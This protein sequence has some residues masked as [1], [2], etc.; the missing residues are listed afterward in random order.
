MA[1]S[2]SN[3][4]QKADVQSEY[5]PSIAPAQSEYAL[6][7]CGSLPPL[8]PLPQSQQSQQP[9]QPSGSTKRAAPKF[10]P[11]LPPIPSDQA[12]KSQSAK[13]QMGPD[14]SVAAPYYQQP[15][16][17]NR[18]PE[19][20][21]NKECGATY[22]A[23]GS[24][25]RVYVKFFRD[26]IGSVLWEVFTVLCIIYTSRH[27]TIP[28]PNQLSRAAIRGIFSCD[29][30][31]YRFP[32][33]EVYKRLAMRLGCLGIHNK[34]VNFL[35]FWRLTYGEIMRINNHLRN[36]SSFQDIELFTFGQDDDG[37]YFMQIKAND[38]TL[39]LVQMINALHDSMKAWEN[40]T[41]VAGIKLDD[42][43]DFTVRASP[44]Y[45]S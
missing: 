26:L 17:G 18:E 37:K 38:F 5:S 41:K 9:Q 19:I 21:Y 3:E 42:W 2:R 31:E 40:A 15:P 22:K 1:H 7:E 29:I 27:N 44:F 10:Q 33:A 16:A 43:R 25:K 30:T 39:N 20:L 14:Q 28:G 24:L 13:P 36:I 12:I 4:D 34:N 6:S 23:V 32:I 35:N 8:P 11:S 45:I